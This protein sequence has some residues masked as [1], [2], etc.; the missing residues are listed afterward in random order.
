MVNAQFLLLLIGISP[1][2]PRTVNLIVFVLLLYFLLRKPAREFFSSRLAEVRATLERAAKDKD[3][4]NKRLAEINSRLERL[5]ADVAEIAAQAER[6]AAVEQERMEN[7]SRM[8]AERLRQMAIREIQAAKQSALLE[9]RDFA[10]EKSVQ[11]AEQMIRKELTLDD[12]KR[13]VDQASRE[14]EGTKQ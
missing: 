10:A 7:E 1:V 4:A 5:D 13:L 11:L 2:V 3:E 8:D 12:D 9:L 6:E 14:F